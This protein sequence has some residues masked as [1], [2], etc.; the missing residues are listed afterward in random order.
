M[1]INLLVV[2]L[3]AIIIMT[4]ETV[5]LGPHDKKLPDWASYILGVVSIGALFA[6]LQYLR[7]ND[8]SAVIDLAI[9]CIAAGV[10]VLAYRAYLD[11]KNLKAI[12]AGHAAEAAA[13]AEMEK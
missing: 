9:V 12:A 4:A 1:D 10:P 7:G 6:L 2:I 13:K 5:I 3:F 8:M 11:R